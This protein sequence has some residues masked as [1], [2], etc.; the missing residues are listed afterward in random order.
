M[1]C[2]R[3]HTGRVSLH[4]SCRASGLRLDRSTT[5]A[6]QEFNRIT[7]QQRC[8]LEI[9]KLGVTSWY[10]S[11]GLSELDFK[12]LIMSSGKEKE[13]GDHR[14]EYSGSQDS[15][16]GRE[17]EGERPPE[18]TSS[19]QELIVAEVAK[20]VKSLLPTLVRP[21]TEVTNRDDR[22]R[23][24]ITPVVGEGQREPVTIHTEVGGSGE[25]KGCSYETFRKCK[26]N[27]FFGTDDPIIA[28]NWLTHIEK[29]FRTSKCAEKDKVEYATNCLHKDAQFWWEN[30]NLDIERGLEAEPTWEEFKTKFMKE[31]CSNTVMKSLEE[32]FLRLQQGTRSVQ[33]YTTEFNEK[34]RFAAHQVDTEE[35]KIDRY[36]WGLRTQIREFLQS[37]S[38]TTYQQIVEAAKSREKE[39][40]RQDNER[41]GDQGSGDQKRKWE[42][43]PEGSSQKQP[44]S[45]YQYRGDL[46]KTE[47]HMARDC[48]EKNRV[49]FNCGESGHIRPDCP[50]PRTDSRRE[51]SRAGRGDNR[52]DRR[53]R[54]GGN[55]RTRAFQMTVEEARERP[56]VITGIF[57]LNS[58]RARM[59]FDTGASVSFIFVPFATRINV[60]VSKMSESLIVD[61]ADGS[62]V[63]VDT[64]YII[65]R[66]E[67]NGISFLIDLK[68]MT[69][70]AFDVIV[71]M[72]WLDNNRA[73][74][75]CHGKI[76][77]VRTP[78]GYTERGALLFMAHVVPIET[79]H[80]TVKDVEIVRDFA[81]VFLTIFRAYRQISWDEHKQHLQLILNLLRKE[82]LY[83][84]FSKCEF[85]MQEIQFLGHVI[86]REGVKVD[87][88]KI[89]AVM[90]W[91][92]PKN[93]TEVRS[94]LGLAG[95]YRRFI[96]KFSSIALPITKLT[97]KTEKFIW[98][99]AQQEAFEKLRRA[100]CEAPVLASPQGV[101]DFVLFTDASQIGLGCVLMQR[102]RVITYSSRQLKPHEQIYPVHDLEL[103]TIIFALKIWRHYL[104]GVKFQIYSDHRSL[105]YLFDKKE[106]N[107]R[108]RRWMDFFK[109]YECEILYHPDKANV[110]AD[111]L[112]RKEPPIRVVSDRM[113]V[114][115]KLPEM[116]QRAQREANDMKSERI[117][118]YVDKL[119]ENAQGWP[120]MKR[121]VGRYVEKCLTCLQVK[122]NHQRPYGLTKSAQFI[123]IR[124]DYQ[125]SKLA[126]IYV[127]E[128]MRR[129]GVPT[130]IISDRDSRFTSHFWQSFQK[131]L[132][133]KAL[134]STAYHPQT[135]GQTERT[136]QTLED[137]LRASVIDF[138]GSW[139]DHLPLAE[140]TYNN[141]YHSS[142][143]MAPFEA[144]YGSMCRTPTCWSEAG[145]KPLAGPE[146]ITETEAKIKSIREH[147]RVAQ[148]RQ[149]QY[150]DKRRK[151]LEFQVGDMVMLKVSPWK[152][153]IRFGKRGKGIHN[154]FH[155]SHLRK[156]LYDESARVPLKEVQLDRKLQYQEQPEKILEKKIK[157]L[158]N[159]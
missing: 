32:D 109:D 37:S 98:A 27:D 4:G 119:V 10:Q 72:D 88:A 22:D 58:L 127:R 154:V 33:E 74:M 103:A 134:M 29:V 57:S 102:G 28:R 147:M 116:I 11:K 3:S 100:L 5:R 104:Y 110:V 157:K 122:A 40:R 47:R 143:Q 92:P 17:S 115:S 124:E 25:S 95:Y 50:K 1:A 19:L 136:I 13:G 145:E 83:A 105:K 12:D 150:V 106:L 53:D 56:N 94:F 36:L 76:I 90:S 107:M 117:V 141:S 16:L 159:K 87:P 18:L 158:R 133:T 65:C 8:N 78:S 42:G 14:D 97:R 38:F 146:I 84:K 24:P 82:K 77:S 21:Q 54:G 26:P 123:P 59:V 149:K 71:G 2:C 68:P 70:R 89:E 120:G 151:P 140:F 15:R 31:Y 61:I 112:S 130:S 7:R 144:L 48:L 35:S 34:A 139:D 111:A 62:D 63:I 46:R 69:T 118:G 93:P 135:D 55:V 148:Q 121:D 99:E 113:G 49:C 20:A 156:T 60:P 44:V 125:A 114:V 9:R 138:G 79:E 137:M 41:K 75:D 86:N 128:M 52:G 153:I 108:Q 39:L 126:E 67:I 152:G 131:H 81:D 85:W 132:G 23:P 43:K 129:H 142:I 64:Q 45:G 51:T 96:E 80:S 66:L 155:I 73:N 30:I 91:A 6:V 101:E